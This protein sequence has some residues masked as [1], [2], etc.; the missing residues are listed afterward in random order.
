MKRLKK[1]KIK[2]FALTSVFCLGGLLLFSTCNKT[3]PG[4]DFLSLPLLYQEAVTP[5]GPGL[6]SIFPENGR[7][8]VDINQ[9]VLLTFDRAVD[10]STL[11]IQSTKGS[12]SGTVQISADDFVTC[13]AGTIGQVDAAATAFLASPTSLLYDNTTY[14]VK[15]TAG[16]TGLDDTV[17][18]IETVQASGFT[19][20]NPLDTGGV[21]LWVRA[22]SPT[23]V[24]NSLGGVASHGNSVQRWR[25]ESGLNNHANQV[26]AGFQPSFQDGALNGRPVLQFDG[27]DDYLEVTAPL[28]DGSAGATFFI[29]VQGQGNPLNAGTGVFGGIQALTVDP[30]IVGFVTFGQGR[31]QFLVGVNTQGVKTST[32][33]IFRTGSSDAFL[34]AGRTQSLET[35]ISDNGITDV[36]NTDNWA[37]NTITAPSSKFIGA[38]NN[39]GAPASFFPGRIAEVLIFNSYLSITEIRT[40]ACH[41][42]RKYGTN[43]TGCP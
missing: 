43:F 40:L 11:T 1:I 19:I 10:L 21:V 14:K 34:L 12:C 9:K 20:F 36:S 8:G 23:A 18:N 17:R 38:I 35:I 4:E 27:G 41:Y 30:F 32:A 2:S 33:P 26:M 25:D 15:V 22:D 28:I 6:L 31:A 39:L 16:I 5:V 13:L 29:I 3:F 24:M 37:G 7:T 42:K